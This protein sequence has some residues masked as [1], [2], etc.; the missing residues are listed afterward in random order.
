[1]DLADIYRIFYP[2]TMENTFFSVAHGNLSQRNN[3]LY[4]KASLK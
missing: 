1:M 4:S 2:G 3:V